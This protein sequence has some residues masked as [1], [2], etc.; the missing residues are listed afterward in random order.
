LRA[1]LTQVELAAAARVTQS[2]VSAYERGRREPSL[3]TLGRLVSATGGDL[4]VDVVFPT[5][6]VTV[7][8]PLRPWIEKLA[9][10]IREAAR[11]HGYDNV[12]LFGSVA[13]GE[14]GP[15]SDVDLLVDGHRG[16]I[17]LAGLTDDLETLLGVPVD[18][19]PSHTLKPDIAKSALAEAVPL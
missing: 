18:V 17:D 3:E 9:P 4:R 2:V 6:R 5:D 12:R 11:R 15:D 13:R 10:D 14:D 16:L 7:G 8:R 19:V 1:G